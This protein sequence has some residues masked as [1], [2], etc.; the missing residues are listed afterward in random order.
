VR[1]QIQNP[2]F[3][4]KLNNGEREREKEREDL[5]FESHSSNLSLYSSKK[6]TT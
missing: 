4:I 6:N 3:N 2:F 1:V 5:K